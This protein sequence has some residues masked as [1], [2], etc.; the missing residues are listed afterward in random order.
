MRRSRR[1]VPILSMDCRKKKNVPVK[2]VLKKIRKFHQLHKRSSRRDA[3]TQSFLF[4]REYS[5]LFVVFATLRLRARERFT[6]KTPT[7]TM[8]PPER[9]N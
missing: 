6:E 5:C 2:H 8:F 4:I 1:F 3:K 7:R 9:Y